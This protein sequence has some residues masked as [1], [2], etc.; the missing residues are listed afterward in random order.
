MDK[1]FGYFVGIG[2]NLEPASNIARAIEGLTVLAG[3]VEVSRI[4]KTEPVNLVTSNRFLNA[5]VYFLTDLDASSLKVR[6]NDLESTLGRDRGEPD[7]ATR[8]RPIDLDILLQTPAGAHV[9]QSADV[10][11][12]SYHRALFLELLHALG[13]ACHLPPEPVRGATEIAFE[14]GNAGLNPFR[15]EHLGDPAQFKLGQ[16]RAVLV[17]GAGVRLGRA[18]AGSLAKRGYDIALHYN[19]SE[20]AAQEAACE[21]RSSGVR[22]ELFAYDLSEPD[23]IGALV[24]NIC[25]RLPHL[26]VMVNSASV[27]QHGSIADTTAAMLQH[28][29]AVNF[30]APFFLMQAFRQSVEHGTIVNILDNKIAYNQFHYA[31]YLSSKKALAELTRMAALEFAPTIRVNGVAPGVVLPASERAQTYLEWRRAAIPTNKLGAP[32]NV[33]DAVACL[34]ENSF[35]NG[36]I[37]FVDGGEA[38]NVVGRNALEFGPA[39][40]ANS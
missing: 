32:S 16:R 27:Y 28:Q 13:F 8:D 23:G 21:F 6:L 20:A 5:V 37:L 26:C 4:L 31:A 9:V 40:N 3:R 30:Q 18:I 25:Q 19:R 39:S 38:M 12:E 1:A 14:A 33:C 2:S 10:P 7:R 11:R 35:I 22:C 15:V 29:W 24:S 34:L 36:Q 17:T